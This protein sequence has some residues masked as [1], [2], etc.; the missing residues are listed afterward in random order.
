M[1]PASSGLTSMAGSE[2]FCEEGGF[3]G[4]LARR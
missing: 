2:V 1:K 4:H 3:D